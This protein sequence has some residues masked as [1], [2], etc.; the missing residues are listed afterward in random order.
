[1]D[2]ATD[3][4]AATDTPT[5]AEPPEIRREDYTPFPWIVPETKLHFDL[6]VAKTTVTATLTVRRNAKADAAQMIR[7]NG[8]GLIAM[9]VTVDGAPNEDWTMDGADLLLSLQGEEHE[10]VITTEIAPDQNTA[11]SGLYASNGM[12]CTQCEAEG[13]RRI[14]FFPDRPDVLSTYSVRMEGPKDQFPILHGK[15]EGVWSFVMFD[16]LKAIRFDQI[17]DRDPAFM[18]G[19]GSRRCKRLAINFYTDQPL[20]AH[21]RSTPYPSLVRMETDRA[22]AGNPSASASVRAAPESTANPEG[23]AF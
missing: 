11:L 10:V 9:S 18:F 6:G 20:L 1:M 5:P 14:T 12:L 2:I 22:C 23:P 7:L 17:K 8:D 13:F 16:D 19:V 4:I 21:V 15:M 3:P